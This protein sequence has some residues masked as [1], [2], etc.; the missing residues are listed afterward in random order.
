MMAKLYT[1]DRCRTATADSAP[2]PGPEDATPPSNFSD[3]KFVLTFLVLTDWKNR[4]G[5]RSRSSSGDLK[6]VQRSGKD[7]EVMN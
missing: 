5:S 1:S 6:E 3:F 7:I 4:E 2:P